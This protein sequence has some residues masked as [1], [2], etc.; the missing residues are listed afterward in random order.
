MWMG[1]RDKHARELATFFFSKIYQ[2]KSVQ[3][4]AELSEPPP[5]EYKILKNRQTIKSI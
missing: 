1:L 2:L 5:F 3:S 4:I